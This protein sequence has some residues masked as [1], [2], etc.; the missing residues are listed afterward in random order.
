[1]NSSTAI[2]RDGGGPL[3]AISLSRLMAVILTLCL[4]LT[5]FVSTSAQAK[6]VAISDLSVTVNK[7]TATAGETLASTMNFCLPSDTAAGDTFT[8]VLPDSLTSWTETFTVKD[9]S[10][11]VI[12]TGV[13][14]N[15]V[16]P[17]TATVTLND[18]YVSTDNPCVVLNLTA[19]VETTVTPGDVLEL[20]YNVG[21]AV[22]GNNS[23]TVVEPDTATPTS[24]AKWGWFRGGTDECRTNTD[25]VGSNDS[26]CIRWAF[27]LPQTGDVTTVTIDDTAPTTGATWTFDCD[28][29][30]VFTDPDERIQITDG[31]TG[32]ADTTGVV[33]TDYSCTPEHLS[34]TLDFSALATGEVAYVYVAAIPDSVN[35]DGEGGDTYDNEATVSYDSEALPLEQH[36]ESS[37]IGGTLIGDNIEILKDD[38]DGNAA[39]TE[40]DAVDLSD[41]D[42]TTELKLTIRNTGTTDLSDIVVSDEIISGSGTV[43]DLTCDFSAYGGPDSGTDGGD[44]VLPSGKTIYCTATL[45]GVT[46]DEVHQDTASVTATGNGEVS[47]SNDYFAKVETMNLVLD[48][49]LTSDSITSPGG[50]VTFELTPSNDGERDAIA[51]WSVTDVLPEG[52]TLVS[53][54]GDG[55][56]CD[57]DTATCVS[58]DAGLAA[59]ETGNVITVTATVD[60]GVTGSLHNVAYV[61]PDEEDV[62]ETNPLVVPTTDTDTDSTDTDNDSQADVSVVGAINLVLDKQL[63][64]EGTVYPGD[65]VTFELTPSNEGPQDASAGWSVTDVLPAGLTMVSMEGDGYDCAVDTATCVSTDAGLAAGETGNVITVTATV[66]ADVTGSLH[67]VAYVS[68]SEDEPYDETNPLEEPD[69]DTDTDTT[70]TDNDS[71]DDVVVATP[72]PSI[73]LEKWDT[74]SG[75]DTGD[76]DDSSDALEIEGDST[77]ITFTVTN[78]GNV[79]LADVTL[80]DVTTDGSGTVENIS[81]PQA[82][83]AVGESMD[84][85]GT[86]SGVFVGDIHTNNAEVVG[87]AVRTDDDGNPVLDEDGNPIPLTDADGNP[88]T[89][90]DEDPWNGEKVAE[91]SVD[92]EKWDSGSGAD[93]GDR[94]DSGDALEIEGD[95]TEITFTVT[96][97]GNVA[98]V[99]VT[100]TDETTDGTGTVGEISCPQ[101]VLAVGESMDCTATLTGVEEGTS[102]TDNVTVVGTGVLTDADGNPVLDEDGNPVP[103]T[104][105]DGNPITVSDEDP[106]NGEKAAD[107]VVVTVPYTSTMSDDSDEE[108]GPTLAHTGA[109][110]GLAGLAL[111]FTF[112]G[113]LLLAVRRRQEA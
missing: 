41:S 8:I 40:V 82:V 111:M 59:G 51:G 106:W 58:T 104:D 69:T 24:V 63:T 10:G 86:L 15:S 60:E 75:A 89:V 54:E 102:H 46:A 37:Y 67:N 103:L 6:E 48:K 14:D 107:T 83:L 72:E 27:V 11:T 13:T 21:G 78:T 84:C 56:D 55:Y 108:S 17:P 18:N 66:D 105:A 32:S 50:T 70:D 99:D 1:M 96:N 112:A 65:E 23:V 85:T 71:Q 101:T 22:D 16:S 81:C 97:T 5:V 4:S 92:V 74:E 62:D 39:D 44:A 30:Y 26:G 53:M 57:V 76:R 38:A 87:T 94:D 43:S 100:V 19:I 35:G 42:G 110:A 31:E 91:P 25:S 61:S 9:A 80:S 7:T 29:L 95:S 77:E 52:L 36:I 3:Q 49:E 93:A 33:V 45:S 2:L 113:G 90:S 88:I 20:D 28:D 98:L 68:P 12:A 79:A 64:S 34:V 109:D 73:D 47:D